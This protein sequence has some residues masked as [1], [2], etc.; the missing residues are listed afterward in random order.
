[1]EKE[2]LEQLE[3]YVFEE[4]KIVTCKWLSKQL[5]I[6]INASRRLLMSLI[7]QGDEELDICY[8]IGGVLPGGS[9]KVL[10]AKQKEL[11]SVKSA[12]KNITLEHVYSIQKN[13]IN[14]LKVSLYSANIYPVQ[15]NE[16][17]FGYS[18]IKCEESV[19]RCSNSLRENNSKGN[20][21]TKAPKDINILKT[22]RV[23]DSSDASCLK[24]PKSVSHKNSGASAALFSSKKGLKTSE[25]KGP[26]KKISPKKNTKGLDAYFSKNHESKVSKNNKS[27]K[28]NGHLSKK[29]NDKIPY[30]LENNLEDVDMF[31]NDDATDHHNDPKTKHSFKSNSMQSSQKDGNKRK[32]YT[33]ED[34][35]GKKHAR[36]DKIN[37]EQEFG[38][39]VPSVAMEETPS[40]SLKDYKKS[41]IGSSNL[42]NDVVSK[43]LTD[44][45]EAVISKN[46]PATS[47]LDNETK[48]ST[49]KNIEINKNFNLMK[50]VQ[51]KHERECE[52]PKD[53]VQEYLKKISPQKIKQAAIT[54]FFAKK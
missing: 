4:G 1:M 5:N 14:D 44:K 38:C 23:D 22:V 39:S 27:H 26:T 18:A 33:D 10:V 45:N 35:Q 32:F 34:I 49:K 16:G 9:H 37:F 43:A 30:P 24:N 48:L 21:Q 2:W 54:N 25:N 52:E 42:E 41:G 40:V 46:R 11:D 8:V 15:D 20:K 3:K 13:V 53:R 6:H 28:D 47:V 12:F 36:T 19:V 50:K 29:G 51:N 17:N 7:N 31:E